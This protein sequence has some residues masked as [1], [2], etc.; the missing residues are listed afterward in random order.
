MNDPSSNILYFNGTNYF[1]LL[2]IALKSIV[3]TSSLQSIIASRE[4]KQKIRP[5]IPPEENSLYVSPPTNTVFITNTN[6]LKKQLNPG[7]NEIT[8]PK[9]SLESNLLDVHVSWHGKDGTLS[10]K[11]L[12][13]KTLTK[14]TPSEYFEDILPSIKRCDLAAQALCVLEVIIPVH[15]TSFKKVN[16]Y[17]KNQKASVKPKVVKSSIKNNP[18]IIE[19][20]ADIILEGSAFQ[21]KIIS[22]LIFVHLGTKLAPWTI[23][24]VKDNLICEPITIINTGYK[25]PVNCTLLMRSLG[26]MEEDCVHPIIFSMKSIDKQKQLFF[27][28]IK[29]GN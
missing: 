20:P 23:N 27:E 5:W 6:K 3:D 7:L 8:L 13:D 22:V 4:R 17:T 1:Q 29:Y 16:G 18:Y 25:G 28:V 2:D 26:Q 11:G 19:H 12:K 15:S 24:R 10:V 9:K 21:D 14:Q